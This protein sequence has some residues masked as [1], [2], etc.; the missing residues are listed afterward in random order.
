MLHFLQ[1]VTEEKLINAVA[2]VMYPSLLIDNHRS[3]CK[4]K[5]SKFVKLHPTNIQRANVV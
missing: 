2:P 5:A 1:R 3:Q 4:L